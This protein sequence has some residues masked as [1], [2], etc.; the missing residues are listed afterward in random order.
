MNILFVGSGKSALKVKEMDL[1]QYY[2][3]AVNN[4]W[5]LF[6]KF[7]VWIHSG[8]FPS[9]NYPKI[10][11]YDKEVSHTG[12]EK[13][14]NMANQ[15]FNWNSAYPQHHIGY[16]IFFLS[17][18]WIMFELKPEKISLLGFDF[19]YN[20]EKVNKW[21]NDNKPNIQNKFN[22]KKEKTIEEWGNNYFKNMNTD[23]FYGHGTPDPMRLGKDVIISKFKLA[24]ESVKK[25]NIDV[26]NLSDVKNTINSF[27]KENEEEIQ[28]D[29][30]SEEKPKS[31]IDTLMSKY[32]STPKTQTVYSPV[33]KRNTHFTPENGNVKS[34]MRGREGKY[35]F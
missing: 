13:T 20:E 32:G 33:V 3:V 1:S 34:V 35:K 15:H 30:L 28:E 31:I 10:K 29:L 4:A 18:Y 17:L 24:K 26:V 16:M 22:N 6:D 8:D 12:Y 27:R 7:D 9:E 14:A 21:I 2:I 25:L 19:D 5:R 23:F 11:N